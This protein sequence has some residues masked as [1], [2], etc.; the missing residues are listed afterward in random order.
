MKEQVLDNLLFGKKSLFWTPDYVD[1]SAW[2]EHIPFAF[3]I[4]EVLQPRVIV[5]L[6][7]HNG[8]SY[9]AFCQALK[10]LNINT[11][12][13]GV[14][15]W[16]GDEHAGFY[17]EAIFKKVSSYNIEKYSRFSTLVRSTFDDALDYFI[18]GSIQLLHIDGLHTYEAVKADFENWKPKLAPNAVVVFHNINVRERNFGVFNLWEELKLQYPALQFDFGHGLGVLTVGNFLQPELADLSNAA[19][20]EDYYAFLRNLFSERGG[21]FKAKW[22]LEQAVKGEREHGHMQLTGREQVTVSYNQLQADYVQLQQNFTAL[23]AS[24]EQLKENFKGLEFHNIKIEENNKSLTASYTQLKENFNGL[25]LHK[26]KIE[27]ENQKLIIQVEALKGELKVLNAGIE[28]KQTVH[29]KEVKD[30][31]IELGKLETELQTQ[32]TYIHELNST[33][34][35]QQKTLDWYRATY[36]DRSLL[37]TIKEKLVS[38]KK[39]VTTEKGLLLQKVNGNEKNLLPST[40][41]GNKKGGSFQLIPANQITYNQAADEYTATGRDPYFIVNLNNKVLKEGWYWISI[42]AEVLKGSL[43]SPKLYYNVGRGFNEQDAWDLPG[44]KGAYIKSLVKLAA[45]VSEFRFDPTVHA[46]T[47]KLH[48]FRIKSLHKLK[49][50]Q[51]ALKSYKQ[52]E[53][54]TSRY[55]Q[56]FAELL[57]T[58]VKGGKLELKKKIKDSIYYKKNIETDEYKNWC[59]QYDTITVEDVETIQ[60]LARELSYQPLFSVIM[61]VFNAPIKFLQKAITSVQAQAYANWELCIA[62][63][64]STDPNVIQLLKKFE[65]EDSRIKVAY[66]SVNGHISKASNS[67]LELATGDYIVLLDQDDEL[68]PHSLYMVAKALNENKELAIIYSDEDKI[69]E[70]GERYDPYFKTDWNPD[71]FYGQ[72]FINHLGVY[73]ASLIKEINGFREG[74]EGSQDYD[75]ALRCIEQISPEQIHHIPHVLYHWR[76]IENSTA[77]TIANKG[78]AFEAG[79]K[80]LN[81]H[82]DRKKYKAQAVENINNSYRVKWSLPEKEPLVSIIIPTKDKVDIL[83]TCITSIIN[84]TEYQNYEVLIID[85]NSVEPATTAYYKSILSTNSKIK[86][87]EYKKEFNFSA[88]VNYGVQ[89]AAGEVV[90]LLN[91]DTEVINE[92]WLAEMVSQCMRKDI[93]AVGAKLYYPNGQIQHAGVF[94]Y[95]GQPG[96]HI[97]LKREKEDPGYFNKLNLVQNYSAVTAACLAIRKEV[98]LEV[99]G[100]DEAH[101]KVAYNDVDLCLKVKALGYRN[102]WTPFVELVHYES[103][104][105]GDDFNEANYKRFKSEQTFMLKKWANEMAHDPYFNPNLAIDTHKTSFAFPPKKEYEWYDLYNRVMERQ[106]T[107]S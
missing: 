59:K 20:N 21:F 14:D 44:I 83:S 31:L 85:N 11:V 104:S 94:L 48:D 73:K 71:L 89:K 29:T 37:G 55:P 41:K 38:G 45:D 28:A 57:S 88:I 46:C 77:A 90:V 24:N 23:A 75:L 53:F 60:L 91:N 84:K 26:N 86:L 13:Y 25:E 18:D 50:F 74:F 66:R 30:L 70:Q 32:K 9:F 54:V 2:I 76:A 68:R 35:S 69:N 106:N 101:L 43:V 16:Q 58:Y 52:D 3:W 39:K 40:A 80:A 92:D 99:N 17:D 65:R 6:G 95:E 64:K 102:L 56:V 81:D 51:I 47:F 98:Y 33:L 105:R 107:L 7:V 1:T 4:V 72:N 96:N 5:E 97:Y 87:Y 22:S 19:C 42:E 61:P 27:K 67:A 78:Y 93:G 10:N 15:T 82:L 8:T 49:A 12:C 34:N 36:E 63:D 100:C 79:I 103:L 62:D